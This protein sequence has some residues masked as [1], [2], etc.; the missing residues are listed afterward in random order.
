MTGNLRP[1]V[2]ASGDRLFP[3]ASGCRGHAG[4]VDTSHGGQ[5][6]QQEHTR[7]TSPA[8]PGEAPTS[9]SLPRLPW[10]VNKTPPE[11]LCNDINNSSYSLP[12]EKKLRMDGT[13]K[14]P[15]SLQAC[16][17]QNENK[18][19]PTA[20]NGTLSERRRH[21]HSPV[22]GAA[23][24]RPRALLQ[25]HLSPLRLFP[26]ENP[27]HVQLCRELPCYVMKNTH[28]PSWGAAL[29]PLAPR[30]NIW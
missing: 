4:S 19:L 3:G 10:L 5:M 6:G 21:H 30:N 2:K 15:V 13:G 28:P 9:G 1:V 12:D 20:Q 22:P 29:Q 7:S 11:R 14:G 25:V 23:G 24:F 8:T 16:S 18:H 17:N 26:H 27:G